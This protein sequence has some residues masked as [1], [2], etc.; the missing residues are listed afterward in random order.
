MELV[1]EGARLTVAEADRAAVIGQV[2]E[3]RLTQREAAA[4]LGLGVRQVKRLVKRHRERGAAGLA[5]ARRGRR[6]NNAI[7]AAVRRAVL[8]LVRERYRDFGPTFACEKLV[9]LHGHR[10]SAETLRGWMI[11]DGLWRAKARRAVREHPSRPRREC[12]GDL[13][14]IDGSPHDWFEGRAPRCTLIVYVDDATSR[15]LAAGFFAAETTEAYMRTTRA[16]LAAHGRP[17]AYYSDRYGVF[18][19]NRRDREGEPTQF[20]RALRTLDIES[21][22]AGSPQA[23]GRV[24]RANRT[25]QDRLVKEMR[26][27]GIS[28]I[29]AGNDYLPT[30]M[31]DYNRRFGVAPRNPADAHRAVLHDARELDLILCGQHARKVTKNLSISFEGDAYQVTGHGKGYRLR[32]ASVTVC[33]GFD[34]TVTVLRDG[35]EL[36]VRLLGEGADPL[37]VEDGKSV[38][39]RVDRAKAEQRSRPAWKPPPDH[40][41]RR[42][43]KPDADSVAAG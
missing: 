12:L 10:L 21:I 7:D 37:P 4:R 1:G 27:R 18:R 23:K 29:A 28:G 31:A 8:E 24:E 30:F 16:H 14:Q 17:V 39:L 43:F 3:R 36:A 34:G 20:V 40:P 15:L 32:G 13:V 25:L 22:H 42:P 9:E 41:W 38:R 19:V 26:L 5:S 11:E 6:P 35:R 33:K 2:V